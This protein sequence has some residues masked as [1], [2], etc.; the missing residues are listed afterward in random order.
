MWGSLV[1]FR[2]C[3]GRVGEAKKGLYTLRKE[4]ALQKPCLC[5]FEIRD[6][7]RDVHPGCRI[8]SSSTKRSES[9]LGKT[10]FENFSIQLSGVGRGC[11]TSPRSRGYNELRGHFRRWCWS[12]SD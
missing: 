6:G 4:S 1:M 11:R 8:K 12:L 3:G 5:V 7:T 10:L 2:T 9:S